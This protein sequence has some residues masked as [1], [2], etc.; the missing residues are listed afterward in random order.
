MPKGQ[1]FTCVGAELDVAALQGPAVSRCG[2]YANVCLD[3]F[4][5]EILV[6][7]SVM[8]KLGLGNDVSCICKLALVEEQSITCYMCLRIFRAGCWVLRPAVLSSA[9]AKSVLFSFVPCLLIVF[10]L[11]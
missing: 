6:D 7:E 11:F 3:F 1:L 10:E 9:Y 5:Y 2:C 4:V 8:K